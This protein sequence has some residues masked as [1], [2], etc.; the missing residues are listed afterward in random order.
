MLK[1]ASDGRMI[2]SA[3]SGG[4]DGKVLWQKIKIAKSGEEDGEIIMAVK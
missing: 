3:Q 4:A 2:R 1:S